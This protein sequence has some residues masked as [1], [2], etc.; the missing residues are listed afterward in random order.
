MK[1]FITSMTINLEIKAETRE[2]AE[3]KFFDATFSIKDPE[4]KELDWMFMTQET[5]E[6]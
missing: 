6:A 5:F 1:T 3:D 4:G 2:E